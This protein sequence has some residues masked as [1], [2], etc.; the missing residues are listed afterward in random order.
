MNER[1]PGYDV[2]DKRFTQSWNEKTREVVD[3]RLS[4]HPGPRFF[5]A[6]E[7]PVVQAICGR[8]LPQPSDR[9]PVPLPAYVDLKLH[10]DR[11]EGYRYA[12]VPEEREAWRRGIAALQAEASDRHRGSFA[13]LP[14]AEQDA[15][16]HAMQRDE[17]KNPAWGDMPPALFFSKRVIPDITNAY[18]AHPTAWSEIGFGGPA[19]PRGYVRMDFNKRDPWEAAEA[20]PGGEEK[21]RRENRRI[22]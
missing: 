18:Y 2:L 22:V 12:G 5:T 17:L 20:H 7:W 14:A 21:A 11:Q 6:E 3:K 1:Y 16:L 4:V 10:E 8:I 19:S 9:P 13:D 15:L